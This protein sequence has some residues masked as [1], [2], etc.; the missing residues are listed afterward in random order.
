MRIEVTDTGCGMEPDVARRVFE[1][2]FTTKPR[3]AGTGLG[4]ATVYGIVTKAGGRVDLSSEPGRGTTFRVTLPA[5]DSPADE[6]AAVATIPEQGAGETV[7]LVEDEQAVRS[8][9]A[10][11][12][13]DGGYDV[14]E[15]GDADE[16]L[17]LAEHRAIDL[18]LTDV[19]MPGRSGS[20]L[21][22]VL[23]DERPWLPVLYMSGYTDDV[24]MRHGVQERKVAFVEK[25][26]TRTTLLG[27]VRA[28]LEDAKRETDAGAGVT[29][30]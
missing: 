2:F 1:P 14:L 5:E 9:A 11:L 16:A 12:L 25:P 22:S 24:T 3:G 20:D 28:V 18:L 8:V 23:R 13:R 26:F 19:V 17:A 29:A 30:G 7:L 15:A 4:L 6:D 27:S 21:A 10:L